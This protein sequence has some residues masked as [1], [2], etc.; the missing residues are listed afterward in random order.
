MDVIILTNNL[1][2]EVKISETS[3]QLNIEIK[4]VSDLKSLIEQMLENTPNTIILDLN[5]L[6]GSL[7]IIQKLIIRRPG[8]KVIGYLAH[9]QIDLKKEAEKYGIQTMPRSEFSKKLPD[10]LR[11]SKR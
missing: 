5:E 11:Q 3:K 6:K 8:L 9:V 4:V 10:I 1:M 2:D 7:E